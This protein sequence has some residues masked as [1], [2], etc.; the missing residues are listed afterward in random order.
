MY[1]KKINCF[2]RPTKTYHER[3]SENATEFVCIDQRLLDMGAGLKTDLL[4]EN[5][6]SFVYAATV[7]VSSYCICPTEFR[8]SGFL[9]VLSSSFFTV[10]P[11]P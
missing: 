10:L 11:E 5:R 8:M 2:K 3:A 7:S 9:C 1:V 4:G 6:S